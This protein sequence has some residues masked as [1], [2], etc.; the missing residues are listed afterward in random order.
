MDWDGKPK[1]YEE[2]R[3]DLRRKK[4]CFSFQESWVLG[5]KC[6]EKDKTDKAHYI[7]VYSDNDSDDKEEQ[8]EQEHGHQTSGDETS[9]AGAKGPDMESMSR[10]PR[11][12]TFRVRGV[13]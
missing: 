8:K 5:Y 1:L 9:Q 2:T 6:V 12:R 13:L 7:E 3:K 11:Y 4:M 10:L